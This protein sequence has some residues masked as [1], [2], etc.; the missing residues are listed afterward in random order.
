MGRDNQMKDRVKHQDK[1]REQRSRNKR[2][3]AER[4]R[5]I[6]KTVLAVILAAMLVI[7]TL[8]PLLGVF[9]E[10]DPGEFRGEFPGEFRGEF[11]IEGR[12]SS[13]R[14]LAVGISNQAAD[15]GAQDQS[16]QNK[17]GGENRSKGVRANAP[18]YDNFYAVV[19]EVLPREIGADEPG[20]SPSGLA[21]SRVTQRLSVRITT[22]GPYKDL[23]IE[24]EFERNAYFNEKYLLAELRPGDQVVLHVEKDKYG[25]IAKAYVADI[26]RQS[27]LLWLVALFFFCLL[28]VGGWKGVKAIL[29]L[30]LTAIMV[31]F[32]FIPLILKGY[33]PVLL[34]IFSCIVVIS[35]S[36]L[37]I[38]GLNRKT[39]A[40]I[41]GTVVGIVIAGLL[42]LLFSAMMKITGAANEH[43]K[44]LIFSAQQIQIDLKGLLFA[45][46]LI[47]S[48]G[49]SMDIG[50]TVSSTVNE[51]G[52][53]SPGISR[54]ALFKAGL[55]VGRD[56]MATMTNTLILAY[57]GTSLNLILLLS[58][59]SI[60][61]IAYLN[62]EILAIEITRALT[63]TIGLV[64]AIP[65]T[66]F[67]AA[68]LFDKK[69]T[70]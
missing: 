44:M 36:F 35:V 46:V 4:R 18:S 68:E 32:V 3:I 17:K 11:R 42:F 34:S 38:S 65:V 23:V 66:A 29:S 33:N 67:I 8:S 15:K 12:P 31:F 48:M 50:M 51:V 16:S 37:I 63:A 10:T 47:A 13:G 61:P 41:A 20:R 54:F 1:V 7:G 2:E 43:A 22:D 59:N 6:L 9:G 24:A 69:V 64:S 45:G 21:N 56:A 19:L 55:N 70:R 5:T 62:W 58:L 57:T 30:L 40:A 52:I 53:N 25:A 39:V 14:E 60:K 49:A 26:K 27:S 28:L